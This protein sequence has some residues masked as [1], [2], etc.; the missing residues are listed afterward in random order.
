MQRMKP[1]MALLVASGLA[2]V[3]GLAFFSTGSA[4]AGNNGQK[5]A[6][7][8][9][10]ADHTAATVTGNNQDGQTTSADINLTG[11]CTT[12]EGF[13]W[14]GNVTIAWAGGTA[15][16]L[17]TTCSVPEVSAQDT[18]QC[19][20]KEIGPRVSGESATSEDDARQK[21]LEECKKLGFTSLEGV[22]VEG[23]PITIENITRISGTCVK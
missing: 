22:E 15:P 18:Q 16:R 17:T 8:K 7:C 3:A 11:E 5:V 9:P 4:F 14:K 12:L 10:R 6:L 19:F 1:K 20:A 2:G 21:A 13:F 23:S